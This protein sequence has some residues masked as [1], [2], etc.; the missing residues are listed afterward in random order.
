MNVVISNTKEGCEIKAGDY[1]IYKR[2][3]SNFQLSIKRDRKGLLSPF[4]TS[5]QSHPSISPQCPTH[6]ASYLLSWHTYRLW[7]LPKFAFCYP[8]H[9]IPSLLP[10]YKYTCFLSPFSHC[11]QKYKHSNHTR[12]FRVAVPMMFTEF[13]LLKWS[14][15]LNLTDLIKFSYVMTESKDPVIISKFHLKRQQ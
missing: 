3:Y 11:P 5:P 7:Y 10:G 12:F 14:Q 6:P 8:G 9:S 15:F 2:F 13:P 1:I 4:I